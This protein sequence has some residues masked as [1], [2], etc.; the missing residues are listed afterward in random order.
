MKIDIKEDFVECETCR[1]KPGSPILCDS[2][3]H[4]RALISAL[5]SSIKPNR[6]I[7]CAAIRNKM[8]SIICGVRH[9]DNIMHD[10][11]GQRS[12]R[13]YWKKSEVEQG[14]VDNE[15]NFL[16]REEA[17]KIAKEQGQVVNRCGGDDNKLFSENLY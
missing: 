1:A 13:P 17:L 5:K 4:N 16:T 7:V 15:G 11:L 9:Y 2:C 8:G 6:R 14:F 12:D 3:L 10:N